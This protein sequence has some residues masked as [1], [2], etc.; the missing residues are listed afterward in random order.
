MAGQTLEEI[1]EQQGQRQALDGLDEVKKMA[2][3]VLRKARNRKYPCLKAFGNDDFCECIASELSV[4]LSFHDYIGITTLEP[5][6]RNASEISDENKKLLEHVIKIRNKC[7]ETVFGKET[8]TG[9][10]SNEPTK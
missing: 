4:W 9:Q 3:E 2:D 5:E 6:E 7:V 10:V 8:K 1:E